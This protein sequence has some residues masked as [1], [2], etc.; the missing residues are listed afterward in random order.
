MKQ[1]LTEL[2]VLTGLVFWSYVIWLGL[3][4]LLT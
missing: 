2:M 1:Q 3:T 4:K